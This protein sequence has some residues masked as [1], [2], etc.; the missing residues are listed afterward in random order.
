MYVI[1]DSSRNIVIDKL[2]TFGSGK[3]LVN[4]NNGCE[5]SVSFDLN[6]VNRDG[7]SSG[8]R[9]LPKEYINKIKLVAEKL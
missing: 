2:T 1:E 7:V 5:D 3:T 4:V 8:T 6:N 9:E